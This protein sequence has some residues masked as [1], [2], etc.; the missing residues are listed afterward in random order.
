MEMHRS[1]QTAIS[2][3]GRFQH[4]SY[5][6]TLLVGVHLFPNISISRVPQIRQAHLFLLTIRYIDSNV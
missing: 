3:E 6:P 1:V 5:V 2:I 4:F